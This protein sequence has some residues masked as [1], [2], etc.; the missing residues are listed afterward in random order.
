MK[1]LAIFGGG[2]MAGIFARHAKQM[3]VES[4]CSSLEEGIV[5]KS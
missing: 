2:H 3:N 1:K 4:H 5:D